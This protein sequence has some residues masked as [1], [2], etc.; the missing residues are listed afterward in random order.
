MHSLSSEAKTPEL[1]FFERWSDMMNAS[2]LI[3]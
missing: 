3:G 2:P 1:V